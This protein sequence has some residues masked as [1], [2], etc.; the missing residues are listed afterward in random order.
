[1]W[2]QSDKTPRIPHQNMVATW[3]FHQQHLTMPSG[4]GPIPPGTEEK[5]FSGWFLHGGRPGTLPRQAG[6]SVLP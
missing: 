2:P 3:L 5:G 1:M 6:D 4:K